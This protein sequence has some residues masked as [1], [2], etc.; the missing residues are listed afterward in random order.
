VTPVISA[1]SRPCDEATIRSTR[2][3]PDCGARRKSWVLVVTILAS[4]M[5][6][7][8]ESVVNVALR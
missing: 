4:T 3:A 7:I 2:I 8:D 5:A 1:K 6:Y